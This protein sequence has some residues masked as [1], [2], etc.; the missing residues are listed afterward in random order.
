VTL[1]VGAITL[2]RKGA[3]AQTLPSI[4]TLARVSV[5]C[6]DKT[7]TITNGE[8]EVDQVIPLKEGFSDDKIGKILAQLMGTLQ[9]SG[10]TALAIRSVYGEN[11]DKTALF[12]M[13]FSSDRKWSGACYPGSGSFIFGAPNF[14]MQPGKISTDTAKRIDAL[15][16][17]GLRVL[18]LAH[19]PEMFTDKTLPGGLK[20]VALIA[21]SDRLRENAAETFGY[22][23]KEGVSLKVIS[24]DHPATVAAVASRAGIP[25]TEA[26]V[27]MSQTKEKDYKSL[28]RDYNVFGRVSPQQK[29]SLVKALKSSGETVCMTGDGVND[30]LAMR[31][32][33]CSVSMAFGSDAARSASDFVLMD[34]NFSAMTGVLAEGRRVINNIEHVASLYLVKTIYAMIITI[35]TIA[36]SYPYPYIALQALPVSALTVAIPTFFLAMQKNYRKP[37][38]A[39]AKNILSYSLPAGLCVVL[40]TAILTVA[41]VMFELSSAEVSTMVVFC[42]GAVGFVLLFRVSQPLNVFNGVMFSVLAAVFVSCFAIPQVASFLELEGLFSRNVFFYI[43]LIFNAPLMI[44]ALGQ[45]FGV[46]MKY[47]V[48]RVE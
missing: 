21:L 40:N 41:G 8:M 43:P 4:E 36:V 6:L 12:A 47:R 37:K 23:I 17:E 38:G 3:L 46:L 10:S 45:V 26:F 25:G 11:T 31:E 28:V 7:G 48:T 15:A 20:P 5:I 19:S 22:F 30:I 13:P 29:R 44:R 35:I 24:G 16:T 27:D 42:I 32:S 2:A 33:D 39:F 9:D 14:V 18:L 34:N 1:T